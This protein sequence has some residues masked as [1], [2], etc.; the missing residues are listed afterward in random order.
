MQWQLIVVLGL[1]ISAVLFIAAVVLYSN[2][3]GVS[4]AVQR[5]LRLRID[6]TRY[7]STTQDDC[8]G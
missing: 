7:R 4:S 8:R 3:R 1:A 2:M 5:L 6:S